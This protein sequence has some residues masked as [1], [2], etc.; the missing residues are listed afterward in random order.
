[1]V[2]RFEIIFLEN[3]FGETIPTLNLH[4]KEGFS[5]ATE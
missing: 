4:S 3:T 2:K 1:M 5:N